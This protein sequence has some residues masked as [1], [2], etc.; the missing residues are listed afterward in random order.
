M[1]GGERGVGEENKRI[2]KQEGE[3]EIRGERQ[4]DEGTEERVREIEKKI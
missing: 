2:G 1:V 4:K 3:R